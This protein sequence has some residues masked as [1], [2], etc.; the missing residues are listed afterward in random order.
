LKQTSNLADNSLFDGLRV[1]T[2]YTV[3]IIKALVHY[4]LLYTTS[5]STVLNLKKEKKK[6]KKHN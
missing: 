5:T 3:N 6:K 2:D 4:K 1:K